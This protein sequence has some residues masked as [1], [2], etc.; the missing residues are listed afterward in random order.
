MPYPKEVST[1]NGKIQITG[2]FSISLKGDP[3]D[4]PMAERLMTALYLKRLLYLSPL[5][6][7]L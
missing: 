4:K 6:H 3:K 7:F 2:G 1:G 5:L